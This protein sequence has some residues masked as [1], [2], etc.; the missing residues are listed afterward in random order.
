MWDPFYCDYDEYPTGEI[1][2]PEDDSEAE[3]EEDGNHVPGFHGSFDDEDSLQS[4]RFC[5]FSMPNK[6]RVD[7]RQNLEQ[8]LPWQINLRMNIHDEIK[9]IDASMTTLNH[10]ELQSSSQMTTKQKEKEITYYVPSYWHSAE[11]YAD[12]PSKH[13]ERQLVKRTS[14]TS[15]RMQIHDKQAKI[16]SLAA[17]IQVLKAQLHQ[18]EKEVVESSDDYFN[19]LAT[20]AL[21]SP[22]HS[23]PV[24]PTLDYAQRPDSPDLSSLY[25]GKSLSL[26][27]QP[28]LY[29]SVT[30]C[31]PDCKPC[32]LDCLLDSGT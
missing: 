15:M 10:P 28:K 20:K 18:L 24:S 25:P 5:M 29:I 32:S 2:Y 7:L 30:F 23:S 12:H 8:T 22:E 27:S 31:P 16:R 11:L 26:V 17:E 3:E 19:H 6:R 1:Y 9:K 4:Y 21:D 13:L 14:Y